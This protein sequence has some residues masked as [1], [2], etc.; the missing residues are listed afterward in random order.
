MQNNAPVYMFSFGG[1]GGKP[2]RNLL[3]GEEAAS[4]VVMKEGE[5]PPLMMAE[6]ATFFHKEGWVEAELLAIEPY[7]VMLPVEP[8]YLECYKQAL[9]GEMGLIIHGKSGPE[10][11]KEKMFR[12][13]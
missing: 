5:A 7:Q 3:H 4:L 1:A 10:L 11:M 13:K 9:I 12:V 8:V 6:I 2:L